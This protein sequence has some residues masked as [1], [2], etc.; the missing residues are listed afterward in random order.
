MTDPTPDTRE[1]LDPD[2]IERCARAAHRA[3][4]GNYPIR[5]WDE[6]DGHHRRSWL[7]TAHAVLSE[8][9]TPPPAAPAPI[10]ADDVRAAERAWNARHLTHNKDKP[11]FVADYL[12][13]RRAETKENNV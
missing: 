13:S 11:A 9:S 7:A 6:I 2:L 5:G 3:Y 1:S 12:N 10:T 8:A 4:F